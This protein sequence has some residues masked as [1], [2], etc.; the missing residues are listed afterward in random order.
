MAYISPYAIIFSLYSSRDSLWRKFG[1]I[2]LSTRKSPWNLGT[3]NVPLLPENGRSE[4]TDA[5]AVREGVGG[6]PQPPM[7]RAKF[8]WAVAMLAIVP[9]Q[10]ES[11]DLYA[12]EIARA[13]ALWEGRAAGERGGHP[14]KKPI[15]DAVQSYER[16]LLTDPASFEARWRL[17]RALHFAG[18]FVFDG[19]QNQSSFFE[20]ATDVSEQGIEL[21]T[22]RSSSRTAPD[23]LDAKALATFVAA[24]K[25]A[26]S[27]IA[28]FYF[29]SAINWGAWSREAGLLRAVRQGVANRL[30][31]YVSVTIALEPDYDAGGAYRLLGRLHAELPR[32]PFVSGGVD[33]DRA[34][35]L[36]EQAYELAPAHPG[37]Q[38]LLG[39]TL[40]ELEP[41]RFAEGRALLTQVAMLTPRAPMLIEDL[42]MREAAKA[43]LEALAQTTKTSGSDQND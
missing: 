31:R 3:R 25:D 6:G 32:V 17:L 18:G 34:I 19:S 43:K 5:A 8:F 2:L 1:S 13:E 42:K 29:W 37:N 35:G 15:L 27:D 21:L 11:A 28:R 33:R 10:A 41:D 26:R 23:E 24:T 22:A 12:D 9:S 4:D 14:R 7:M 20:R 16:A 40:I 30:N 39:L 38:L 36:I